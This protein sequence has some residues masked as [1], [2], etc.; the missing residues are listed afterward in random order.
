MVIIIGWLVIEDISCKVETS[1]WLHALVHL[2]LLKCSPI[3]ELSRL[4]V[5]EEVNVNESVTLWHFVIWIWLMKVVCDQNC[6]DIESMLPPK[7]NGVALWCVY[8][9]EPT[10]YIL[11][12]SIKVLWDLMYLIKLFLHQLS[13]C[14]T[15]KHELYL[16]Q[17]T[18]NNDNIGDVVI[19]NLF[20][21]FNEWN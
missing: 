13:T 8:L 1:T 3:R 18:F 11:M 20:T 14:T 9:F 21:F 10:S 6:G 16:W 4:Q 7:V 19:C 12:S 2:R 5:Y 15:F 17:F